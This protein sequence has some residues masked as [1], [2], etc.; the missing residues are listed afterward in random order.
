MKKLT[1]KYVLS[2]LTP[3]TDYADTY[4]CGIAKNNKDRYM[5]SV[6]EKVE[7]WVI[8]NGGKFQK[9]SRKIFMGDK[10][11][12]LVKIIFPT[13]NKRDMKNVM[14]SLYCQ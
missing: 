11:G 8:K 13:F 2:H 14:Q 12:F 4:L 5:Y 1:D 7:N 6:S 9:I 10:K 3:A